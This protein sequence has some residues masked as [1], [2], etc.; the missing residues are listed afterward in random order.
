MSI[1]DLKSA[2][3]NGYAERRYEYYLKRLLRIE[4]FITLENDETHCHYQVT[5][6]YLRLLNLMTRLI[7]RLSAE[8]HRLTIEQTRLPGI[9]EPFEDRELN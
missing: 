9:E 2:R 1:Q 7:H 3:R 4:S 5:T 8:V 6:R